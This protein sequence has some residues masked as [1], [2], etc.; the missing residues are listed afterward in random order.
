MSEHLPAHTESYSDGKSID[1]KS[2]VSI[3]C[4]IREYQYPTTIRSIL[5]KRMEKLP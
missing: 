1:T 2:I 3:P 4:Q 5:E